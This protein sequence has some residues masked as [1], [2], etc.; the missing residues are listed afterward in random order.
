MS[1]NHAISRVSLGNTFL[2]VD[3]TDDV[4]RFGM[5]PPGDPGRKVLV[6]DGKSAALAQ[7]PLPEASDHQLKLHCEIDCSNQAAVGAKIGVIATG[8]PDYELRTSAREAREEGISAALISSAFRASAGSLAL[9]QQASSSI[10]AL[11][12]NFSWNAEGAFV[13]LM[14]ELD[15]HWTLQAPF[16]VPK[17]WDLAL[18]RRQLPLFL[19]QGFPLLLEE[20]IEFALPPQ[21]R[22]AVLP[23]VRQNESQP[24]RW[25]VEWARVA[26]NKL[27]ARFRAELA[28]G[29]LLESET[30]TFQNQLGAL[31]NAL[32]AGAGIFLPPAT[33]RN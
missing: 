11:D 30:V 8:Y 25:R 3:T 12:Q 13:G 31:R 4:C 2:W 32:A 27:V 16:W 22:A 21:R 26:E 7:L 5:L 18:G 19:N 9:E 24:L 6:I 1:F 33:V 17:Q 14:S 23:A 20:E 28:R 15:D 10:A 29:E